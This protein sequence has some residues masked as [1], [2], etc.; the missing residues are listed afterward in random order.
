MTDQGLPCVGEGREAGKGKKEG[1]QRDTRELLGV[2]DMFIYLDYGDDGFRSVYIF[3]NI[4]N[5][6]LQICAVYFKSII[7]Q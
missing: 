2:V 1:L 3:Q 7:P 4:S 6:T 5:Y